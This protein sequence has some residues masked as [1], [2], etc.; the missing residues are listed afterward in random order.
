MLVALFDAHST[1]RATLSIFA[2]FDNKTRGIG[3]MAGWW[4][5]D[6]GIDAGL[7]FEGSVIVIFSSSDLALLFS[8]FSFSSDSSYALLASQARE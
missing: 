1:P 7:R 5:W 8:S 6:V 3:E 4:W 2:D